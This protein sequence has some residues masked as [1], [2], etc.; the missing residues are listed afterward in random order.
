M[1]FM[2]KI[3]DLIAK[4]ADSE[5]SAQNLQENIVEMEIKTVKKSKIKNGFVTFL[6]DP[7]IVKNHILDKPERKV[8]IVIWFPADIFE[9]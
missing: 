6:T 1:N 2:A 9:R 7:E 3:P 8:G 5:I 4:C